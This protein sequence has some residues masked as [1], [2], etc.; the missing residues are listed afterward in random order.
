MN[1]NATNT[2]T[3]TLVLRAGCVTRQMPN[4]PNGGYYYKASEPKGRGEQILP[5]A[6]GTEVHILRSEKGSWYVSFSQLSEKDGSPKSDQFGGKFEVHVEKNK[7]MGSAEAAKYINRP[8]GP[9]KTNLQGGG[10]T[11]RLQNMQVSVGTQQSTPGTKSAMDELKEAEEHLAR[12]REKAKL[13]LELKK[14][15]VEELEQ[16]ERAMAPAPEVA[17]PEEV[18]P[19]ESTGFPELSEEAMAGGV[20]AGSAEI[21]EE[22]PELSEEELEKATNPE[23]ASNG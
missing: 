3:K 8:K 19:S 20:D 22:I 9:S 16:I 21:A 15:E 5:Y 11:S 23:A 6:D 2:H 12:V 17:A 7:V 1:M 13:D 18:V 14:K 10:V 4:G